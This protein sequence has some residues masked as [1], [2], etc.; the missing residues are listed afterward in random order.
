M[1]N[2]TICKHRRAHDGI[3]A[4]LIC[5]MGRNHE[6]FASFGTNCPEYIKEDK[7]QEQEQYKPKANPALISYIGNAE[8]WKSTPRGPRGKEE[9][10]L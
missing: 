5:S 8:K 7:N 9:V 2:C 3:D 6:A 4:P 1:S 10:K